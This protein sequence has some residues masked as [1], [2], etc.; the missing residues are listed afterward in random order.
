MP[1]RRAKGRRGFATEEVLITAA[2]LAC[3]VLPV[4]AASRVIGKRLAQQMDHAERVI[5]TR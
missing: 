2:L 3:F 5:L 4:A 1:R